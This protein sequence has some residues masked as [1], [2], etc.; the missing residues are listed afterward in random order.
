M[1]NATKQIV[2]GFPALCRS[3]SCALMLAAAPVAAPAADMGPFQGRWDAASTDCSH[4]EGDGVFVVE[5]RS[6]RFYESI[7][8][9]GA[10]Q[11]TGV[12]N[13]VTGR[14]SCEG[15]GEA[16]TEELILART[17]DN[18]LIVFYGNGYGFIAG[19][20]GR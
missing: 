5:P 11:P 4:P 19:R 9:V 6:I 8:D 10:V 3:A 13:A 17:E 12:G 16:W 1:T 14:M 15:E 7:C 18:T 20:C 2:A